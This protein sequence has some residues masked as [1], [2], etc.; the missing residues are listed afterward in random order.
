MAIL[1]GN[2]AVPAPAAAHVVAKDIAKGYS[3]IQALAP[4]SFSVSPGER[5]ALAGPSGSGKTTLLYLLAGLLQPDAGTLSI[6][7]HD[8][9]MLKPGRD[10]ARLVGMVHQ[11]YDLVSSLPVVHNVLAGR[12]GQ[13]SLVS[14]ALSLIW[15][16]ERH[17][18]EDAL[19]RLGIADKLNQRTSRLSGGEQQRVAIARL[20][21]QSPRIIL[22]DE[23]VSSLDPALAE[24]MMRLLVDLVEAVNP[25][26]KDSGKTLIASLHSPYL[27]R[28]YCTRVIGL[29]HGQ[30][31]FD[32]PAADL[33]E[34]VLDRLYDLDRRQPGSRQEG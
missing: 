33:S 5:L 3:G 15:P 21:V 32:L 9:S 23:P 11:Q 34:A 28:K 20:M 6:D 14:S 19:A 10:L 31:Q 12:L 22:A 18:A 16:R 8:L 4:L 26:A 2:P 1:D 17:L 7:G 29:R 24:E 13:W 27:I 25:R 30:M